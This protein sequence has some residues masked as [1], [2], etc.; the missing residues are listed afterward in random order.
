M[1]PLGNSAPGDCAVVPCC[2]NRSDPVGQ[3]TR[4]LAPGVA[5][6]KTRTSELLAHIHQTHD[7][8]LM[9]TYQERAPR[10]NYPACRPSVGSGQLHL[11]ESRVSTAARSAAA[12]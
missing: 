8:I 6:M 2:P 4:H 12:P 3:V 10:V 11:L 5:T 9:I 7:T 1:L